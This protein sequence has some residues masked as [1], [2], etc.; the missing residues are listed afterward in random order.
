VAGGH[1]VSYADMIK[2]DLAYV[3]TW[4]IRRDLWFILMTIPTVLVRR[5]VY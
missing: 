4:S 2:L 5:S 3:E 1:A